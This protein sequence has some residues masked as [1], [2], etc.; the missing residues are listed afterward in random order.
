MKNNQTPKQIFTD[1][2]NIWSDP[3][4][5]PET[6]STAV[7]YATTAPSRLLLTVKKFL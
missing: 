4:L 1:L 2:T 7:V 5:E 6:S 3:G